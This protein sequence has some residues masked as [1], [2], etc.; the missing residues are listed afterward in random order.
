MDSRYL[1]LLSINVFITNDHVCV[2]ICHHHNP[3]IFSCITYNR[4][5]NKSNM[6]WSHV[7]QESLSRPEHPN[8]PLSRFLVGIVLLHR[9]FSVQCFI[10]HCLSFCR[11]TFG[12]CSVCPSSIDCFW[13]PFW[14]LQTCPV[15]THFTIRLF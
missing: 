1:I 10:N 5:Y 12:H 7:E 14:Y 8:S 6:T 11:I 2:P 4:V 9:Q 3:V 15:D 13:L